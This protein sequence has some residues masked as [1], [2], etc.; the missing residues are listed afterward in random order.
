VLAR[1]FG[2]LARRVQARVISALQQVRHQAITHAMLAGPFPQSFA[3]F[4]WVLRLV[5]QPEVLVA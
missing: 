1:G 2:A 3:M 5:K 4:W